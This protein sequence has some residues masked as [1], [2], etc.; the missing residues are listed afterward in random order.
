MICDTNRSKKGGKMDFYM[1]Y[2]FCVFQKKLSSQNLE[3]LKSF[4][5]E[6]VTNVAF[7]LFFT[8]SILTF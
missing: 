4:C 1:K 5:D 8:K 2:V 7:S 3:V 6:S